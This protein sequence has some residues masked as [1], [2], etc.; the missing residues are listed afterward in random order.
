M[1]KVVLALVRRLVRLENWSRPTARR[2]RHAHRITT[3]QLGASIFEVCLNKRRTTHAVQTAF[4]TR[5]CLGFDALVVITKVA[6]ANRTLGVLG[7]LN[8]HRRRRC[9]CNWY[10]TCTCGCTIQYVLRNRLTPLDGMSDPDEREPLLVVVSLDSPPPSP[11]QPPLQP[12]SCDG[13]CW[14]LLRWLWCCAGA[15]SS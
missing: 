5:R 3:Q 6:Q 1:T 12:P 14:R 11:L 4:A 15:G 10:K 13:R 8:N 9:H 2:A 7:R